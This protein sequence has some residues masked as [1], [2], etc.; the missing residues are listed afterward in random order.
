M[1]NLFPESDD[2]LT[3]EEFGKNLT[4]F[5]KHLERYKG[6]GKNTITDAFINNSSRV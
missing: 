4:L 3:L 1:V 5:S 2:D 6:G